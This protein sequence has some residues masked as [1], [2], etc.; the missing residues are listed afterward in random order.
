LIGFYLLSGSIKISI[1]F[2]ILLAGFSIHEWTDFRDTQTH[3]ELEV[4]GWSA[5]KIDDLEVRKLLKDNFPPHQ[6]NLNYYKIKQ[7]NNCLKNSPCAINLITE[8]N[9]RV[10]DEEKQ[11]NLAREKTKKI[12]LKKNGLKI[13]NYT[14]KYPIIFFLV[15]FIIF[16]IIESISI[17]VSSIYD[18]IIII[19]IIYDHTRIPEERS[20]VG[21]IIFLSFFRVSIIA[22]CMLVFTSIV[23]IF[24][25]ENKITL[26]IETTILIL[27]LVAF[28]T[29]SSAI[30][31][32]DK[33]LLRN[34]HSMK[35]TNRCKKNIYY[36]YFI[37]IIIIY[38]IFF[39]RIPAQ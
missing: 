26:G 6:V 39:I 31:Y 17:L 37:F 27:L 33:N 28:I 25:H 1:Y 3:Q 18:Y 38:L 22:L 23:F 35:N 13:F 21:R 8:I 2:F 11:L 14:F 15:I 32:C 7:P 16:F 5:E 19:P 36:I 4:L 30:F 34:D 24:P 12:I 10:E 20:L 9:K 29:A